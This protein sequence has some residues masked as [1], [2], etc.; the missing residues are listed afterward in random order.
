[1]FRLVCVLVYSCHVESSTLHTS[2]QDREVQNVRKAVDFQEWI[3]VIRRVM[4]FAVRLLTIRLPCTGGWV[5]CGLHD[6]SLP[7]LH[8][9]VL[10]LM[11]CVP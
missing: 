11:L 3:S 4:S 5:L 10:C 2:P 8:V 9:W 1:M 6:A 7:P